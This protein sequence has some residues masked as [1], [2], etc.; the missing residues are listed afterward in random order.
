MDALQVGVD[1]WG[2]D[3]DHFGSDKH[4]WISNISIFP[5]NP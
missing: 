3:I 2:V 4:L 5:K 1:P